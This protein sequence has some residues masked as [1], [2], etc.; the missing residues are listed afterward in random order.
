MIAMLLPLQCIL[1]LSV[2]QILRASL[3]FFTLYALL[4][5]NLLIQN[6]QA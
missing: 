6:P 1:A 4:Y 5:L 3:W 2:R